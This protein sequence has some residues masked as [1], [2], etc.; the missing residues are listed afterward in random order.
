ML[1][2]A[3]YLCVRAGAAPDRLAVT[4]VYFAIVRFAAVGTRTSA[5]AVVS[6]AVCRPCVRWCVVLSSLPSHMLPLILPSSL[7]LLSSPRDVVSFAVSH[8]FASSVR[9]KFVANRSQPRR[10]ISSPSACM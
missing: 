1:S 6:L 7:L 3:T 5:P 4:A 9:P 10:L 2:L 8:T